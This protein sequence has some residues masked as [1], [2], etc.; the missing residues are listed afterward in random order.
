VLRFDGSIKLFPHHV[1][2]GMIAKIYEPA[3]EA[4][5]IQVS[6]EMKLVTGDVNAC[7][8]FPDFKAFTEQRSQMVFR[9]FE[10]QHMTR[11][12]TPDEN[13]WLLN[14][15]ETCLKNLRVVDIHHDNKDIL[16]FRLLKEKSPLDNKA[17]DSEPYGT[18]SGHVTGFGELKDATMYQTRAD[19]P[20]LYVSYPVAVVF[21]Q[22]YEERMLSLESP[23]AARVADVHHCGR[24]ILQNKDP[25]GRWYKK[26]L[27]GFVRGLPENS[28]LYGKFMHSWQI[29]LFLVRL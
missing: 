4:G 29:K 2:A 18:L 3:V 24:E 15:A 27:A 28:G 14:T 1:A 21:S 10:T 11:P 9:N 23:Y 16:V 12:M 5:M 13:R 22:D 26:L 20:C 25:Y 17:I 7:S 8:Y 6:E 19:G